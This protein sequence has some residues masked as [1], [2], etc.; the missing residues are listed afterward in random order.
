MIDFKN[1]NKKLVDLIFFALDHGID[2]VKGGG[3][4]IPFAV[5]ETNGKKTLN[6]FVPEDFSKMD[7]CLQKAHAFIANISPTPDFVA[8]TFDGRVTIQ[9][10]KTDA[11][12]VKGFDKTQ[13]EGFVFAQRYKPK[14]FLR[15]LKTI[16][17]AGYLG[18]EPNPMKK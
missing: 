17:N 3:P 13:D 8:I 12:M 9:G 14:A 11:I 6:R 1:A 16:G 4:L 18:N 5:A 15:K 10:E 2:S 7:E